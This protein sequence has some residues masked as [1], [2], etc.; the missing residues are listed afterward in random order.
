MSS[1]R[2]ELCHLYYGVDLVMGEVEPGEVVAAR[3]DDDLYDLGVVVAEVEDLYPCP[4]AHAE[5]GVGQGLHIAVTVG[6]F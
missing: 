4:P 1:L 2:V 6:R 5:A 3:E